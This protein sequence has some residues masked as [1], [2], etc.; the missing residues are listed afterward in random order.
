MLVPPMRDS[1][2]F[3]KEFL[4]DA[5]VLLPAKLGGKTTKKTCD[6]AFPHDR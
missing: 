2:F 1:K 4:P 3:L 5:E 6:S